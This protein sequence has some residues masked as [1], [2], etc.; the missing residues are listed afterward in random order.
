M[1]MDTI[2]HGIS[3]SMKD[4]FLKC[5]TYHIY[6]HVLWDY[7]KSFINKRIG[8]K[9]LMSPHKKKDKNPLHV[10]LNLV[11]WFHLEMGKETNLRKVEEL[12]LSDKEIFFEV[13]GDSF[14]PIVVYVLPINVSIL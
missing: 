1:E 5:A 7:E 3:D 4:K 10:D 11:S 2:L 8:W 13:G 6:G 14:Y 12:V 9:I